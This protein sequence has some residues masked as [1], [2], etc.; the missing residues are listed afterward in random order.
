MSLVKFELYAQVFANNNITNDN[1][2]TSCDFTKE[3]IS[4]YTDEGSFFSFPNSKLFPI[5]DSDTLSIV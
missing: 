4:P 1:S 3:Y 2:I 5:I